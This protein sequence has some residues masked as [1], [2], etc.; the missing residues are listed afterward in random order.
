MPR[1]GRLLWSS[2]WLPPIYSTHGLYPAETLNLILC[3]YRL[4]LSEKADGLLRG[5]EAAAF[6]GPCPANLAVT[7]RPDGST[8][9]S[10]VDFT[11]TSSMFVR[12]V[13][14]GL[15]GVQMNVPD[16]WALVQPSFP[17]DWESASLRTVDAGYEY[18]RMGR[19]ETLKVQTARPLRYRV[20]LRARSAEVLGVE[21]NGEK[22]SFSIEPGVGWAWVVVETETSEQATIRVEYG[23]RKLPVTSSEP[24]GA[25]GEDY[26]FSVM[27]G[28]ILEVRDPQ[29][30]IGQKQ[31]SGANCLVRFTH[32]PCWHTFFVLAEEDQVQAW[33]PIDLELRAPLEIVNA[34]MTNGKCTCAV[35]N[36]TQ[37]PR[38]INGLVEV[39]GSKAR[40]EGT[41]P[42]R[43]TTP[44]EVQIDDMS[45]LSPGTNLITFA[46][47][48]HGIRGELIDWKQTANANAVR[49]VPLG[50]F[51]NQELATLHERSYVWPKTQHYTMTVSRTAGRGG[52]GEAEGP[53]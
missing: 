36:N 7:Q 8:R 4:G 42:A 51:I 41:V 53:R 32:R 40:L 34:R 35:R 30:I 45:R 24:V 27:N 50:K 38:R 14:E 25:V 29:G 11:D 21:V 1:G 20:R 17:T 47:S 48:D 12:T 13:V 2:N 15:F 10:H 16:G 33:L 3:Y 39:A 9:G 31:V 5:I 43:G 52:T 6:F 26:T 28:R 23:E 46:E 18:N 22:K 49:T 44:V 19:A 37:R